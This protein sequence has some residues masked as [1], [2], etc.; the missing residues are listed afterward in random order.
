MRS[1]L[2]VSLEDAVLVLDA[3]LAEAERAGTAVAV[4]VVDSG[5]HL[6]AFGRMDGATFLAAAPAVA[7]AA[8]SAGTGSTTEDF[9]RFL[10]R[11]P[12]ALAGFTGQPGLSVLPGGLPILD[13]AGTVVGGIGVVG[14]APAVERQIGLAGLNAVAG[15]VATVGG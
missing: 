1:T 7:K 12:V 10:G 15:P 2:A 8:T 9:G 3:A 5:G 11:D 13:S 4:A 6:V 14:A